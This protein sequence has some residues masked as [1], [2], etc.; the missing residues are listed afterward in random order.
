MFVT[1]S[2]LSVFI[3]DVM[4]SCYPHLAVGLGHTSP[5]VYARADLIRNYIWWFDGIGGAGFSDALFIAPIV[6]AFSW[7][8]YC[9]KKVAPSVQATTPPIAP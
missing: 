9:N 2:F 3:V 7:W 5:E 8:C 4:V 1:L 6:A